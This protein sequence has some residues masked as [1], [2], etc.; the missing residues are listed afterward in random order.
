MSENRLQITR[1]KVITNLDYVCAF[2]L[3]LCPILQH[4]VGPLYNMAISSLAAIAVYLIVRMRK[5]LLS[6]SYPKIKFVL[7]MIIYQLYRIVNHGTSVTE[8]GQSMVFIVF[9][10]AV[11]FGK[12]N[13][14]LVVEISRIVAIIASAGLILQYISFYIFKTH[15]QMVPT[16]LLIPSADQ[17]ILGAQTGLAG[18]TGK[19]SNFYRPSAFFLEPSHVYLF[20]FPHIILLLFDGKLNKKRFFSALFISVALALTTSGMG[21]AAVFGIWVLFIAI[22]DEKDGSFNLNNLFRRRNLVIIG[23]LV[24]IFVIAVFNVPFLKR[25]VLRIFVPGKSGSTAI[26][27][28]IKKALSLILDMSPMQWLL[29]AEDVKQQISF[30]V[31]GI[32][33]VIYRH[34]FV[35]FVLSYELYVKCIFKLSFAYKFIGIVVLITS[36]FSAHTHSTVGML[37]FLLILMSGFECVD[38]PQPGVCHYDMLSSEKE[39][40][41]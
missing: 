9:M 6:I 20:F 31:P 30:N 36:L 23:V 32:F 28:R 12:I 39:A 14:K 29:G 8:I 15:I 17:W 40:S 4:Y 16:S 37:N 13:L 24:V 3:A 7:V 41:V 10:L 11:A 26:T 21:I 18:I 27:G 34:G 25:A 35:G 38:P 22:R 1:E 33:D 19:L 2:L 5:D